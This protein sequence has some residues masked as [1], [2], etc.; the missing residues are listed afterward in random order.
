MEDFEKEIKTYESV[1]NSAIRRFSFMKDYTKEDL[2]QE[3]YIVLF[4][5]LTTNEKQDQFALNQKRAYVKILLLNRFDKMYEDYIY[6]HNMDILIENRKQ[7]FREAC[8]KC[9]AK[10]REEYREKGKIRMQKYRD[11]NHDY[12]IEYWREY[13]EKNRERIKKYQEEY[14][15]KNGKE[16]YEKNKERIKKYSKEYYERNKEK[17]KERNKEYREKNREKINARNK[18]RYWRLKKEKELKK[19]G[20]KGNI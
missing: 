5:Y 8:R 15:K 1:I 11:E 13:K 12:M 10:H 18:E 2:R 16:Y 6:F 17:I 7:Y 14:Y 9:Y 3:A 4:N 19:I 20:E